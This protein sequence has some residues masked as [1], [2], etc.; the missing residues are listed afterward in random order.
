[1]RR[2][3]EI[4]VVALGLLIGPVMVPAP[5]PGG[6]ILPA[7][8]VDIFSGT[9]QAVQPDEVLAD[10]AL[11]HRARALS[12][13]LR[14]LVCQNQSI[15]DSDAALAKD[16][17]VLV[18]DRLEEGDS[19]Q[20]VVDYIVARYGEFV[21]LKPRLSIETIVLWATPIALILAGGAFALFASRRRKREPASAGLTVDEES[22]VER[23]LAERG[24]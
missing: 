1:M 15:D 21:L 6:G 24:L 23:A 18:R 7:P 9:A 19:D 10:P 17:R 3:L 12:A 8:F 22:A 2:L 16:L 4:A 13:G 20:Q 14:C 11:E 5:I